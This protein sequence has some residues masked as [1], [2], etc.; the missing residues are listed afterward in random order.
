MLA[1]S[2]GTSRKISTLKSFR[3]DPIGF[4]RSAASNSSS[5]AP[6]FTIAGRRI[7]LLK[8]AEDIE[9]VLVQEQRQFKKGPGLLRLRGILGDGLLTASSEQHLKSRKI[10]QPAFSGPKITEYGST[11]P[12][13][14]DRVIQD[15]TDGQLLDQQSEMARLTLSIVVSALFNSNT[16]PDHAQ[17]GAAIDSSLETL[18]GPL[19]ACP[20]ASSERSPKCQLRKVL[21]D[22]ESGHRTTS[23]TDLFSLIVESELT[24]AEKFD[25]SVTFLLGGHESVSIA[26]TWTWFALSQNPDI[27]EKFETEIDPLTPGMLTPENLPY[28]RK[29]VAESLRYYPPAWM[30]SREAI[31]G[32]EVGGALY[33]AGTIFVAA[34]CVTHQ[35]SRYWENPEK[36]DPERWD[37]DQMKKSNRRRYAYFPFGGGVRR[38]I[39]EQ[40][41]LTELPIV[42]ATVG[43]K[44]R[45]D[46][47]VGAE[48]PAFDPVVTLRPRGGLPMVVSK[49]RP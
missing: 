4:L 30:F 7:V 38:C 36:F 21:D 28:T 20:H 9:L 1:I 27:R 11:M 47:P 37:A 45:L 15:W 32:V 31:K 44:W 19:S 16:I 29:I 17:V 23:S 6:E 18:Y 48:P 33:P 49:R 46:P 43:K 12:E 10:L 8:D 14:V 22:V 42:L 40:F 26:L 3:K 5:S 41:A 25:E 24:D 39:G 2:L 35:D 34:P 13:I